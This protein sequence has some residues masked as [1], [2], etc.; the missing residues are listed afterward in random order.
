MNSYNFGET[1]VLEIA[2]EKPE[3]LLKMKESPSRG[4][5]M[6]VL[7]HILDHRVRNTEFLEKLNERGR[8]VSL[9]TDD[10]SYILK[11]LPSAY[12]IARANNPDIKNVAATLS[13]AVAE[14]VM[15]TEALSENELVSMVRNLPRCFAFIDNPTDRVQSEFMSAVRQ[16]Y[17]LRRR[18]V[19]SAAANK[20]GL[21]KDLKMAMARAGIEPRKIVGAEEDVIIASIKADPKNI[22]S[23]LVITHEMRMVAFRNYGNLIRKIGTSSPL[24]QAERE[25]LAAVRQNGMS[26]DLKT[27]SDAVRLAAVRQNGS[28]I[29]DIPKGERTDEMYLEAAISCG[30]LSAC[31]SDAVLERIGD[32]LARAQ[33]KYVALF[34]TQTE[35]Q[36]M[37]AVEAR[38]FDVKRLK[39]PTAAVVQAA[40]EKQPSIARYLDE[41]LLSMVSIEHIRT[42]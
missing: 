14:E 31:L 4:L 15:T 36:Q 35:A 32:D 33:P 17:P 42:Q 6:A 1:T 37:L 41:N 8:L 40:L 28:L 22:L 12:L 26:V 20:P 7:D 5:L 13:Y 10:W 38:P 30:T 34:K 11:L 25:R 16:M 27:A 2:L 24:W 19:L 9:T 3:I 29:F 21:R 23:P 39:N 18:G